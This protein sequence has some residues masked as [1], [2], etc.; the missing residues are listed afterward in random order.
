MKKKVVIVLITLMLLP[1][2]AS[3][4]I[5][6]FR[7]GYFVPRTSGGEDSLWKIEFDNMTLKKS[8][9][10][11]GMLGLAYELFLNRQ[12]SLVF[13]VDFYSRDKAG[14]YRE[15]SM[16]KIQDMDF[17]LPAQYYP[18]GD[19]IL[20]SFSVSQT[21][22]QVSLKVTPL[23]RQV[24]F[25]PYFGGGLGVYFWSVKLSG[26][27]ID[28]SDPYYLEDEQLGEVTI[29]PVYYTYASESKRISLGT[30]VFAGVMIPL[31]RQVTL[32]LNFRYQFLKPG[33]R[34]AFEGFENFDLSGYTL[35][36]GINYWF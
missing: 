31:G 1:V 19:M 8:D 17:A 13:S 24:R 15:W 4:D 26:D 14:F 6:T 27:M 29:Y 21:P 18:Y 35:V 16:Y 5:F 23:G 32:D 10:Q 2:A 20:H 11:T 25:V 34:D 28:F 3:A 12:F 33:F 30:S 36:A 22:L 9:Y 7:Y